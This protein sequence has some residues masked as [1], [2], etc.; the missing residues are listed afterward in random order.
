[1]AQKISVEVIKKKQVASRV[2][3]VTF[4]L[5]EPDS[6]S[7]AAGQNMM[8]MIAPA[9]EGR[10][11]VNR[12]MSIASPPSSD[13]ELLM[14]H[15]VSPM[16][17]GSKWTLGLAVGDK[18][19]VVA[20]TGGTLSFRDTK[21][22]KVLV[23]TGT[24]AAPFRSMVLD[25]IDRGKHIPTI[26]YWG[27]RHEEDIYW[28]DDF[29]DIAKRASEFSWNLVLSKPQKSW[30]GKKGHVTEH[31]F[32]EEKDMVHS[33]FYLCGNRLMIE[34]VR[35]KLLEQKV[36]KEQIVTELFY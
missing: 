1:M 34:D 21:R 26:L 18:A 22:R 14:V 17:P 4:A 25:A 35:K 28:K 8:L 20:P 32:F 31:V 15:D 7:F 10:P 16:G 13:S 27:L 3:L 2:Y 23:A 5:I 11:G 6:I 29:D 36:P 19:T 30:T 12:T 24:G 9:S 33:E